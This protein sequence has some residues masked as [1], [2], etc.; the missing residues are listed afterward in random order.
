MSNHILAGVYAAA[1]TPL[2]PDYAPDLE[3]IPHLLSFLTRR[4]CHGALLLGTTGEGPSFETSERARI[5][6]AALEVRQE[7]PD[8]RLL[9]GTGTPSLTE[10]THLT[11]TAFD[12]GFEGAV[13]LPPYY[14]RQ[15]TDEGLLVWYRELINRAV[16]EDGYIFGYH[17]PT[18]S[19]VPL[20]LDLLSQLKDEFPSR[21]AGIKDS[22]GDPRFS[23]LLG[24]RFGSE[25]V[26]LNG[27][28]TLLSHALE[29]RAAGCI[30]AMGNLFSPDL[31]TVWDA[32]QRGEKALEAQGRLNVQRAVLNK[33]LPFAP[34]LKAL[35]ARLHDFPRWPVC[36]PL[37]PLPDGQL[38][39]A[40]QEF[41]QS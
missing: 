34:T 4:G 39:Q 41:V 20:S 35:L 1:L 2:Q 5:F 25:F 21:F 10:T 7:H 17:I 38:E 18:Q 3:A 16:P 36:P 31:R 8:F 14:F 6:R 40:L 29:N 13:V 24:E 30:T 32:H 33:Y 23:Q 9:A 15:A 26:V 22:T 27:N 12:L 19:G 11:K 37:Q 28:D